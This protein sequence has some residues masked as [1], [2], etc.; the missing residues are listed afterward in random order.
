MLSNI[1]KSEGLSYDGTS[2]QSGAPTWA[3]PILFDQVTLKRT[4]TGKDLFS[5]LLCTAGESLFTGIALVV[6]S[7]SLIS[8]IKVFRYGYADNSGQVGRDAY[9]DRHVMLI[10]AVL[11]GDRILPSPR[12]GKYEQHAFGRWR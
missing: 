1:Y 6:L 8:L 11:I 7:H 5:P 9:P 3:R 2:H 12:L 4:L 10:I